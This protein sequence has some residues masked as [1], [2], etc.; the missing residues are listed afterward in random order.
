MARLACSRE[1]GL[2]MV[3]I[4]R[5]FVIRHVAGGTSPAGQVVIAV[6]MALRALQAG[7]R[8]S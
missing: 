8:S 4:G 6:L 1:R 5:A 7:V 2:H 3:G